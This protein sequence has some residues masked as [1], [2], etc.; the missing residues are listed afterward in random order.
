MRT[1]LL[2]VAL[3]L[4]PSTFVACS[5]NSAPLLEVRSRLSAIDL[6]GG[7]GR[8]LRIFKLGY[9][10]IV[11]GLDLAEPVVV[12]FRRYALHSLTA[13]PGQDVEN[14]DLR[15]ALRGGQWR[16]WNSVLDAQRVAR[17]RHQRAGR[18]IAV[19]TLGG[20]V[21]R[22]VAREVMRRKHPV[23][24]APLPWRYRS[25]FAGESPSGIEAKQWALGGM[26]Q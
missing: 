18:M 16:N 11:A 22:N 24:D 26:W 9:Y 15:D 19:W 20:L 13:S 14:D 21:D 23:Q 8:C 1:R 7:V 25:V 6:A 2:A 17:N 5:G 4:L 10:F 3:D 12:L